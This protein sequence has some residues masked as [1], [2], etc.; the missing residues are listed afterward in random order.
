MNVGVMKDYK[1][2][3][4]H[5]SHTLGIEG[6]QFKTKLRNSRNYMFKNFCFLFS[7]TLTSETL[8]FGACAYAVGYACLWR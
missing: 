3:D 4:L 7:L 1:L 8:S 6:L 2:R 5:A